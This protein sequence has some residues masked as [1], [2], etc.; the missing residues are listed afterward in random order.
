MRCA[1]RC[2]YQ[3]W[4]YDLD[5]RLVAA[6]NLAKDD[7]CRPVRVRP[8]E[9]ALREWLGYAWVCLADEPP[10]F[11]EMVH[12]AGEC[13]H[14]ATIRPELTNVLPEFADRYAAQHYVGTRPSSAR[15]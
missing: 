9:V 7:R 11:E 8:V 13:C 1:L 5:G 4:T 12:G 3:A 14:C 2:P 6:P 10:S 15:G